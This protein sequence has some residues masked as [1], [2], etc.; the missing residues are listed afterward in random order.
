MVKMRIM[1]FWVQSGDHGNLED[2]SSTP[3]TCEVFFKKAKYNT[4][5]VSR[6]SDIGKWMGMKAHEPTYP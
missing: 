5:G 6:T 1:K 3:R 4:K 2:E